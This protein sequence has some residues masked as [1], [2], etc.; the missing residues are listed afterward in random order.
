MAISLISCQKQPV[1]SFGSS[2]V[3]NNNN[4]KVAVADTFGVNMSTVYLDSIATA[5]TGTMMIGRYTDPAFGTIMSRSFLQIGPPS[6]LPVISSF[7]GY[8]SIALIMRTN[9]GFY[10]GDTTIPQTFNVY[11]LPY[12]Y[13][14]PYQQSTFFS[15]SSFPFDNSNPLGSQTTTI[16]PNASYTT[17]LAGD[18]VKIKLSDVLG[19]D[20]YNKV[21]NNSDTVRNATNFYYWFGG[22]CISPS[23]ASKGDIYGFKDSV[24]M[25]VYYHEPGVVL[26]NKFID[27]EIAN[28]AL[29]FN[30]ITHDKTASPW[31]KLV[32]PTQNPQTPP[33]TP[34]SATGGA[35][36]LQPATGLQ[37]KLTFPTLRNLILRPD[38]LSVIRATLTVRPAQGAYSTIYK[39][40]TTLGL[41]STDQNNLAQ[42]PLS[43]PS[44]AL[45]GD[46]FIDYLY[47]ATTAYNYDI[48][49]YV[50]QQIALNTV[51]QN[52]L[53]LNIPSGGNTNFARAVLA[54]NTAPVAQRVSLKIYYV[55]LFLFP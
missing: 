38:Y 55:S 45:T 17:Q 11:R 46:L 16:F 18:S 44:G 23:D 13:Q 9:K 35:A 49:S 36:Y 50:Q 43:G 28:G 29:Q 39:L 12:Y 47:G 54:D 40:P 15:N 37:V 20:L 27:F 1:T 2:Y 8:D 52:G 7:A 6:T 5:G 48:T 33:L 21:Y 30:N 25:R 4:A 31:N 51:N 22:L 41:Y 42:F 24:I 19:R 3:Q 10:Y 26:T 14:L 34:S 32:L 53:I